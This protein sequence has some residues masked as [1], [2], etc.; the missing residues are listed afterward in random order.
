MQKRRTGDPQR[1]RDVHGIREPE[2]FTRLSEALY[3][4]KEDIAKGARYF[5]NQPHRR[6]L[7]QN[8]YTRGLPFKH[9]SA[10]ATKVA[11]A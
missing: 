3:E 11:N 6:K 10:T 8:P 4:L 5:W 2:A 1:R 7:P 9:E